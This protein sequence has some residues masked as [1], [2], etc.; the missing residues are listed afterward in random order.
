MQKKQS[1]A[2]TKAV[3]GVIDQEKERNKGKETNKK[4]V[5][6]KCFKKCE[7]KEGDSDDLL[8]VDDNDKKIPLIPLIPGI[9]FI[10]FFAFKEM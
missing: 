7:D 8:L 10:V 4:A 6:Q 3:N 2:H 5:N 1:V 9:A